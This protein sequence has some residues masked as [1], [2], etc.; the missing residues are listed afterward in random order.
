MKSAIRRIAI[1]Q[2]GIDVD[3]LQRGPPAGL[4]VARDAVEIGAPP[5]LAD[6]LDHLDRRDG[7]ELLVDVAII[8]QPDF[9]AVGQSRFGDLSL[10]PSLLLGRQGQSDD[11]R[12]ALR[13]LDRQAPPTAADL[14]QPLAGLQVRA[15]RA[16]GAI[17]WRCASSSALSCSPPRRRIG[18]RRVEPGGIEIIPEVVMGGDIVRA[19]CGCV[20]AEPVGERIEPAERAFGPC[21]LRQARSRWRENSSNNRDRVGARPFA[22]VP[23][24][25]PADR[26]RG[27]QP[28]ERHT[29]C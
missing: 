21:R 8:L 3:E 28:N 19:P 1:E 25:V 17:L 12:A 9:D 5:A 6:R 4:E 15:G 26:S 14:E 2:V 18:H 29:S 24:L 10:G 16:S 13:R 22:Q 7:V 20:V 11:V 27:R 23:R